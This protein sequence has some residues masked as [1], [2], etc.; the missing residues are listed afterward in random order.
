MHRLHRVQEG[1]HVG[2]L[3]LGL[4]PLLAGLARMLNAKGALWPR[5]AIHR[6][7]QSE[8][9]IRTHADVDV[10]AQPRERRADRVFP[11]LQNMV[12]WHNGR[13]ARGRINHILRRGRPLFQ[14]HHRIDCTRIKVVI[15][16][17]ARRVRCARRLLFANVP[18]KVVRLNTEVEEPSLSPILIANRGSKIAPLRLV[19]IGRRM[20]RAETHVAQRARHAHHEGRFHQL[21][22]LPIF[23]HIPQLRFEVG[24]RKLA[25]A[26]DA[27]RFSRNA[28]NHQRFAHI[29]IQAILIGMFRLAAIRIVNRAQRLKAFVARLAFRVQ[30]QV[31]LPLRNLRNLPPHVLPA[32][33]PEI[34]GVAPA[35]F[36]RRKIAAIILVRVSV[37]FLRGRKRQREDSQ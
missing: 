28:R 8:P 24:I 37:G 36:F 16:G 31:D 33:C 13:F 9:V 6:I 5:F 2:H 34:P 35:R 22:L 17:R 14:I 30:Q 27:C 21:R 23:V 12:H 25:Q 1:F 18:G 26:H 15:G 4:A 29:Q 10:H 11:G 19:R 32:A 20:Q 3:R 7:L